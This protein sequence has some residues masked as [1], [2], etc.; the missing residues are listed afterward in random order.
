MQAINQCWHQPP[1]QAPSPAA[2]PK[3]TSNFDLGSSWSRICAGTIQYRGGAVPFPVYLPFNRFETLE[4][5]GHAAVFE[6]TVAERR[7]QAWVVPDHTT[8]EPRFVHAQGG[9]DKATELAFTDHT[10]HAVPAA[11]QSRAPGALDETIPTEQSLLLQVHVRITSSKSEPVLLPTEDP[12][13]RQ[14]P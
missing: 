5:G 6:L 10:L 13:F 9:I 1:G 8:G 4:R 11:A 3:A 14:Q 2:G 12:A 7:L